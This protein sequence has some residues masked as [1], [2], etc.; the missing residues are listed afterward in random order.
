MG[1]HLGVRDRRPD[2]MLEE[3][4]IKRDRFGELFD[5]TVGFLA[6]SSAPGFARHPPLPH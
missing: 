4:T 1:E 6:E 2:V 3:P 5:A